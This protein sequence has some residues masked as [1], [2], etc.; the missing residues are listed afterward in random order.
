MARKVVYDRLAL[1]GLENI[2]AYIKEH[3]GER[4]S[5][6][7]LNDYLIKINQIRDN[8]SLFPFVNKRKDEQLHIAVLNMRTVILFRFTDSEVKVEVIADSR[9]DWYKLGQ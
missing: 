2:L 7:F 4:R 5:E 9:S 8:P 1:I 3:F 6:Q